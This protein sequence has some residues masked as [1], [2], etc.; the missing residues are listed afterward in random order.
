MKPE[1]DSQLGVLPLCR[2]FFEYL[3]EKGIVYCHWKS[4]Y[5]LL[6]GLRGNAD[7]DLLVDE[8]DERR[9]NESVGLFGMKRV[10]SPPEKRFPGMKD[11]LGFDVDSGELVHLHVH[12]KLVLGQQYIKNHHLN[13]E[14]FVLSN[15]TRQLGVTVPIPELE[16]LLLL[17]RAHLKVRVIDLWRGIL[18]RPSFPYP[19]DIT[20]ELRWLSRKCE[21]N[22]CRDVL[23]RSG[24]P[25]S[26]ACILGFLNKFKHGHQTARDI[27]QL[28]HHIFDKLRPYQRKRAYLC[29]TRSYWEALRRVYG[30]RR[31][32]P[33]KKKTV[34]RA[35]KVVALVGADG[36]GKTTSSRDLEEWL[37]WKLRV[38]RLYFGIPKTWGL[39]V[40]AKLIEVV[41][42]VSEAR[43]GAPLAPLLSSI[44]C[45]MSTR[46]WVRIAKVRRRLSRRARDVANAGGIVIADRYP[47]RMFQCM[48]IP[49]DGPRVRKGNSG[50]VA[51][52]ADREEALYRDVVPPD[53]VFVLQASLDVLSERQ[54][55]MPFWRMKMKVEAV[56]SVGPAEGLHLVDSTRPYEEVL[57]EL[58]RK[59]WDLL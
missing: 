38:R 49:M 19:E 26:E 16:L 9:F 29:I 45:A 59:I 14:R 8:G 23:A 18:S 53:Y 34:P 10:L 25:L 39:A 30:V 31:I 41:E 21:R 54:D 20:S 4:N 55:E 51:K 1:A 56:N 7:L 47:L 17:I 5:R 42:R 2:S 52:W 48:D 57:R 33:V 32:F 43:C 44:A 24:L 50:D 6:E 27:L 58:K 11:Y 28:R 40:A 22:V 35:G 37:S 46:R 12:F 13:I 3:A 36:S 15:T